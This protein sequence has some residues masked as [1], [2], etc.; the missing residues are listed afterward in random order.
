M[1]CC[2]GK[3]TGFRK[4]RS[5]GFVPLLH[6]SLAVWLWA[7]KWPPLFSFLNCMQESTKPIS[8]GYLEDYIRS[9]EPKC[10]SHSQARHR[11]SIHSDF[12]FFLPL[13]FIDPPQNGSFISP[14]SSQFKS[15]GYRD[16][17]LCSSS[18]MT[19]KSATLR[20]WK[21]G[22]CPGLCDFEGVALILPQPH[23]SLQ[24]RVSGVKGLC[25]I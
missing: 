21:R 23:P 25:P 7:R 9:H 22:H 20:S 2:C 15:W 4:S 1:T 16:S 18:S 17:S 5:P 6:D 10:I 13:L 12:L 24:G 3:N 14:P 11:C 8:Q 19:S